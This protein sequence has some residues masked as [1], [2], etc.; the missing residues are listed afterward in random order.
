MFHWLIRS[1]QITTNS[2]PMSKRIAQLHHHTVILEAA[3]RAVSSTSSCCSSQ[4]EPV[5]KPIKGKMRT[6]HHN[7]VLQSPAEVI[8]KTAL[9]PSSTKAGPN[10]NLHCQAPFLIPH[11]TV[12]GA[13]LFWKTAY[14][15]G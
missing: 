3:S 6:N 1:L 4:C 7:R 5:F 11:E 14:D 2:N 8:W 9:S 10:I 12:S 13:L 15:P